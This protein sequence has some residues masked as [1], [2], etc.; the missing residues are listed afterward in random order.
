ME[1][2]TIGDRLYE[3][4]AERDLSYREISRMIGTTN[5]VWRR[6]EVGETI[7][8]AK[9]IIAICETFNVSADWLLGLSERRKK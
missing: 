2:Q 4:R 9:V 8:S 1:K 3:I 7:P 6:W 5:T